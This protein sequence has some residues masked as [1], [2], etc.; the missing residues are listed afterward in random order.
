M[1]RVR[2]LESATRARLAGDKARPSPSWT[3]HAG[4]RRNS[5]CARSQNACSPAA[6]KTVAAQI[7]TKRTKFFRAPNRPGRRTDEVRRASIEV[8]GLVTGQ[9]EDH[10]ANRQVDFVK[11]HDDLYVMNAD[12]SNPKRLTFRDWLV[13]SGLIVTLSG[14]VRR[15]IEA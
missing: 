10:H 15:R 3:K 5:A 6:G 8:G 1:D 9:Q 11:A 14:V 2:S 4:S 13:T 7:R 12:G